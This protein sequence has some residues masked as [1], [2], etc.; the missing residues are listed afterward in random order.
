[1]A[2]N[3]NKLL[4]QAQK[5]QAQVMRAQE[6]LQ[7]KEVVG[8]AGGGMV[9]VTMNGANE[10]TGVSINPQVVDPQDVEMLEDLIVAAFNNA[11]EKV[12]EMS[13]SAFGAVTNGINIPGLT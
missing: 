3:V 11:N 13:N 10:I 7:K 4:K 8:D 9:K 1:M 5:M 6:E 12:K 2:Q